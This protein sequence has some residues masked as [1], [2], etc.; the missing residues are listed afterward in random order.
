MPNP[1]LPDPRP[2]SLYGLRFDQLEGLVRQAFARSGGK[3]KGG[4]VARAVYRRVLAESAPGSGPVASAAAL[5]EG[6]GASAATAALFASVVDAELPLEPV[7]TA[8]DEG[9]GGAA[10]VVWRTRDGKAVETVLVPPVGPGADNALCVSSQVG[11]AMGCAFCETGRLGLERNLT[12]AEIVGQVVGAK[13]LLGWRFR[14]I[15]FMGMGEPLD[16]FDEVVQALSVLMDQSGIGL[17]QDRLTVCTVG[18]AE[19]IRRLRGLGWTR[20]GLSLSLNAAVQEKREKLM[21]AARS[22]PLDVLQAAVAAYP[23][24]RNF[25]V[26]LNYIL[27]PG[28]N[29][30]VEDADA[31]AAF[32]ASAGRVFVNLIPYNPGSAPIAPCPDRAGIDAFLA[33]LHDRGLDARVRGPRGRSIMAACGQLGGKG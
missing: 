4:G 1:A 22:N 29:D 9:E 20:V 24:R 31:V 14:N 21:P 26:A 10:K 25:V 32:A 19:G 2:A 6:T 18:L 17:A 5:A 15:V 13:L 27:L 12:A 3:A 11:C 7:S 33:L 16:N 8:A 23:Q 30:T 28:V